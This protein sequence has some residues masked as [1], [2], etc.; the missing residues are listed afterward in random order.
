MLDRF[1]LV[2]LADTHAGSKHG[3]RNPDWII[4]RKEMEQDE[5]G[6][7]HYVIEDYNPP[8]E[9]PQKL[10]WNKYLE[11]IDKFVKIAGDDPIF[12]IHL[13]EVCEGTYYANSSMNLKKDEQVQIAVANMAPWKEIENVKM[14]RICSGDRPHEFDEGAAAKIVAGRLKNFFPDVRAVNHGLLDVGGFKI[15]YAHRGP[16]PGSRKWLEGNVARYYLTDYM[17]REQI[18]F[19]RKPA[20][21]VLRAHYHEPVEER[22]SLRY[23]DGMI[24]SS[25]LIA[26]CLKFPDAYAKTVTGNRFSAAIGTTAVEVV[27]GKLYDFHDNF[28]VVDTRTWEVYDG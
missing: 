15:D 17:M 24:R 7:W 20:D 1:L 13:A 2:V 3:L 5:D 25:I 22:R 4:Q 27:K 14:V 26:P 19:G 16:A 23:R 11:G 10:L 18:E 28:T 8:L 6:N 12:V 21:L 9:P